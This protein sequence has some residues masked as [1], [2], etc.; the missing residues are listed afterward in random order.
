MVLD[1]TNNKRVDTGLLER[2][3]GEVERMASNTTSMTDERSCSNQVCSVDSQVNICN[4]STNA[5]PE[6]RKSRKTEHL[7]EFLGK[8][9]KQVCLHYYLFICFLML[10]RPKFLQYMFLLKT[11]PIF[12]SRQFERSF[13]CLLV[14][15]IC[16]LIIV[17]SLALFP[18][19]ISCYDFEQLS[20]YILI[21]LPHM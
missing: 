11:E 1:I 15:C 21:L 17:V 13:P 6:V 10:P 8:V 20:F 2:I 4:E 18:K 5:E 7:L 16:L 14:C 12:Q 9:L 19:K 3:V